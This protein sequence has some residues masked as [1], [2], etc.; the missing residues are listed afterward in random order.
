MA[1]I[2]SPRTPS[3]DR[4]SQRSSIVA[5]DANIRSKAITP[6]P[7]AQIS[8][9]QHPQ[10]RATF[11]RETSLASPPATLKSAP[12]IT[13]VGLYGEVPPVESVQTMD[14]EQLRTLVQELIPALGEARVSAA[15]S[16]LQHSMLTIQN[17]EAIMRAEVEHAATK[18]EVA[19][20]Q[21][22]KPNIHGFSPKSSQTSVHRNLHLALSHCRELQIENVILD[23]RL[24]SSK[25]MIA[26]LDGEN[27]DLKNRNHELHERI[28]ANRAHLNKMQQSGVISI[29]GTPMTEFGTPLP[30]GTPRTPATS[31]TIRNHGSGTIGSQTP[32]DQ[33]VFAGQ[34]MN[35]EPTSV[36]GTPSP[37]KPSKSHS[38]HTR[39]AY[40]LS[41]LPSTPNQAL[42]LVRNEISSAEQ[43]IK[44][45]HG[46]L[47]PSTTK[48]SHEDQMLDRNERETTISLSDDEDDPMIDDDIPGSQASQ[49]ATVMLRRSLGSQNSGPAPN[50]GK[51]L[52]GRI[53]GQVKKSSVAR[54]E[55]SLKR[56]A[57]AVSHD[58]AV[59]SNKKAKMTNFGTERRQSV[60]LGIKDW[61][62]SRR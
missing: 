42:P 47:S 53:I 24:R 54:D 61:S 2:A 10:L 38:Q 39:G 25:R 41:S 6:P 18:R 31:R 32:F 11:G 19:V 56:S 30:K 44:G 48:H 49:Q 12:P 7:S 40:S 33:L 1:D 59:G 37:T 9:V 35:G 13:S 58:E 45:S 52:Q 57:H 50:S 60:G 21:E 62:S 51:L 55:P 4:N 16:K 29:H 43:L 15:H 27:M 36:P 22:G 28:K 3:P 14:K 8:A 5:T 34:L 17:E 23:K 46:R 20:L 26:R